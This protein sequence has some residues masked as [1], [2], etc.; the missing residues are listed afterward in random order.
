MIAVSAA[1]SD[2]TVREAPPRLLRFLEGLTDPAVGA[3]LAAA[4][5]TDAHIDEAWALFDELRLVSRLGRQARNDAPEAIAACEEWH[6]TDLARLR[7]LW[8]LYHPEEAQA[9]LH[10]G[11]F[12][13]KGLGAVFDAKTFLDRWGDREE[14]LV[15]KERLEELRD[16]VTRARSTAT[17]PGTKDEEE[18][19]RARDAIK[20]RMHAWVTAWSEI[21]RTMLV[22]RDHRIRLG[23][24]TRRSGRA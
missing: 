7:A 11:F 3:A 14:A 5:L 6:A 24:A 17:P 21:A 22:R 13:A 23:I 2:S 8:A 20:R 12:D 19:A 10:D 15:T 16:H 9:L 4:G 18:R 1:A